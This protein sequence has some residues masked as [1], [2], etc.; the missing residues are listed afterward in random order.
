MTATTDLITKTCTL[1]GIDVFD[2]M[3]TR[4]GHNTPAYNRHLQTADHKLAL[5]RA[6]QAP[7]WDAPTPYSGT[8]LPKGTRVRGYRGG[9]VTRDVFTVAAVSGRGFYV[10]VADGET[11]GN[12][13]HHSELATIKPTAVA[14]IPADLRGPDL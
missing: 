1:C 12:S 8:D 9:A 2:G 13:W 11:T 4:T 6:A 14:A 10:I 7:D 3:N 5:T